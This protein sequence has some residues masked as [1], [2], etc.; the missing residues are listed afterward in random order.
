VLDGERIV[1]GWNP[2]SL[3]AAL[4]GGG[5]DDPRPRRSDVA[6]SGAAG[7]WTLHLGRLADADELLR[8]AAAPDA[9]ATRFDYGWQILHVRMSPESGAWQL[10]AELA[11]RTRS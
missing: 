11:G 1:V 7:G 2:E 3:H 6:D 5:R 4:A 9:P 8:R 10:Q